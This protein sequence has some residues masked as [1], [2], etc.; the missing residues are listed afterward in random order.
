MEISNIDPQVQHLFSSTKEDLLTNHW[1][2]INILNNL[3]E[4]DFGSVHY[5]LNDYY[6]GII[7][8][9]INEAKSYFNCQSND[10]EI[11]N[12]NVCDISQLYLARLYLLK[13][14]DIL[15]HYVEIEYSEQEQIAINNFI[16]KLS[17]FDNKILATYSK[18]IITILSKI[19]FLNFCRAIQVLDTQLGVSIH[20]VMDIM[21]NCYSANPSD[22]DNIEFMYASEILK[23][24]LLLLREH[25]DL[26][27]LFSLIRIRLINEFLNSDSDND[28]DFY[29]DKIL[30]EI[31]TEQ[32]IKLHI[33][34]EL[35]LFMSFA[36]QGND[37]IENISAL[38]LDMHQTLK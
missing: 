17:T 29:R 6:P 3:S 35:E 18:P 8:Y 34:S 22:F 16:I 2:F 12:Y 38:L 20:Y 30:T 36:N 27:K 11:S 32:F 4:D 33:E 26:N 15:K 28:E 13:K 21:K 19:S 14:N 9:Y 7:H 25:K 10:N 5:A 1:E 23:R 24:R 37:L 31:K